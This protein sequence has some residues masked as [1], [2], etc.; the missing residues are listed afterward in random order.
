M[1]DRLMRVAAT[2]FAIA[3]LSTTLAVAGPY[4]PA[5]R[6]SGSTAIANTSPSLV[7]WASGYANLVR[8]PLD[9]ANPDG[10]S[11]SFGSG[12]EALGPADGNSSHVVSLGDGGQ[13]T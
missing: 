1:E 3:I 6:Q 13:I 12:G 9:I 5:A 10:G 2:L 11:A 4:A 7:E 8:G